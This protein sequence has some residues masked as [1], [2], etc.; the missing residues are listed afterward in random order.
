MPED[1][2]ISTDNTTNKKIISP[3]EPFV[4]NDIVVTPFEIP[5]D[6][7]EPVGIHIKTDKFKAAVATDIGI[8]TEEIEEYIS[9]VNILL[10]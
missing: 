4:I 5:H 9:D 7:M 1:S 10:V 6:A 2:A 3:G 8:A